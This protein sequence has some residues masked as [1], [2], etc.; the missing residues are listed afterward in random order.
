MKYKSCQ[1]INRGI[2]FRTD[3]LRLCCYGYLQD[4]EKEYQTTIKE[5]YHGELPDWDEIFIIKNKLKQMHKEGRYLQACDGCIYLQ[6]KDWDEEN[7]INHFTFNHWTK[8]NCNCTYCYTKDNKAVFNSFKEYKLYPIIKDMFKKGIIKKTNESCIIFGGGEPTILSD[9]DKLID[10][11]LKNGCQ[12]IR[13]NS[14]GIK[15]SKS[16]ANGLKNGAISLVISTDSGCSQTYEK[17]KQVKCYNKVWNNIRKYAKSQ[18]TRE[19]VKVKYI[20]YPGVNDNYEEI[21]KWLKEVV[22]NGVSAIAL[23]VE[24][25][26]YYDTQ[27]DFTPEIFEQIEYIEKRAEEL[28]LELEIYCEALSVLKRHKN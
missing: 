28:S 17:I 22:K 1:W 25:H 16:I 21:D 27:P 18:K 26:W 3:C 9:F 24:Q 12:N 19:L 7:Y 5:N 14:S 15:Y 11:F 8:C 20:L 2:E 4:M 23:S 10:L 6:E 13:I